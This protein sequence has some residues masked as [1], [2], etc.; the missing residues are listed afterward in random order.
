[1][2]NKLQCAHDNIE[3]DEEDKENHFKA[4]AEVFELSIVPREILANYRRIMAESCT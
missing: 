1:M 4:A 2:R 3:D